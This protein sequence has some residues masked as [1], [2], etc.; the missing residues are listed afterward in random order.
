MQ[1]LLDE[2]PAQI[3]ETADANHLAAD[4]FSMP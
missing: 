3:V 1:T 4:Y 2:V